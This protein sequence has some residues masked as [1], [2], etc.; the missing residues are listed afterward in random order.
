MDINPV[1]GKRTHIVTE[2]VG[3]AVR[4]VRR[5]VFPRFW[6]KRKRPAGLL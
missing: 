6:F 4:T 1:M 5:E 2:Q 3:G